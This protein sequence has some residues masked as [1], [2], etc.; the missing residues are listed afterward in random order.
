MIWFIMGGFVLVILLFVFAPLYRADFKARPVSVESQTE[1]EAYRAQ[2]EDVDAQI[3]KG[4]GD[5]NELLETKRQL[6]RQLL[7]TDSAAAGALNAAPVSPVL[8]SGL[9]IAFAFGAMGIYGMI[10]SP[11][12]KN[13]IVRAPAVLSPSQALS[14]SGMPE[15]END[16]SLEQLVV[17]LEQKLQS[18]PTNPEG[19]I[20]YARSLMTLKRFDEAMLAYGRVMTL[21]GNNPNVAEEMQS[22]GAFIQQQTGI[23]PTLPAQAMPPVNSMPPSNPM[24]PI[25]QGNAPGP[26]AADV[27]AAASL[28]DE[29]RAAMIEGM[30]EGLAFKLEDNPNDPD[31]WVRLLRARK[32]LGQNEIAKTEI[33]ALKTVFANQPDLA[34]QIV[35]Q[36]G[37]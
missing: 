36:A 19:W 37:Y 15:H 31:G 10:G 11:P 23:A 9:L 29:G 33:E 6:Q 8:A 13:K 3:A 34:N 26:T 24:P 20:L 32:V 30:V 2:I 7:Q 18:D 28:S 25:L 22:A 27:Q 14:Q 5:T 21:S 16:M 1:V 4:E 17:G 35:Q 12:Q